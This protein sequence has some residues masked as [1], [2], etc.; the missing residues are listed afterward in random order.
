M[1][2]NNGNEPVIKMTYSLEGENY[3]TLWAK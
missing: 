2:E 1:N 3:E